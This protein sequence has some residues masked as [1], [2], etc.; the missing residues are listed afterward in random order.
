MSEPRRESS[1]PGSPQVPQP[2]HSVPRV[3]ADGSVPARTE[4]RVRPRDLRVL[5]SPD[6]VPDPDV[7]LV[8]GVQAQD[9]LLRA[10]GRWSAA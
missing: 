8:A 9:L 10:H 6:E 5:V 7:H 3:P 1:A 2:R 4:M